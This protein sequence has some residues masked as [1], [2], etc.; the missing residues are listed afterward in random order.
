MFESIQ[1][2][3]SIA[4]LFFIIGSSSII[5]DEEPIEKFSKILYSLL[6]IAISV[7]VLESST[8]L[9][10]LIADFAKYK[11]ISTP[12]NLPIVTV[13]KLVLAV[14][15]L[16]IASNTLSSIST[17]AL[18]SGKLKWIK[19]ILIIIFLVGIA[20]FDLRGLRIL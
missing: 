6:M 4:L 13:G 10:H 7:L 5:S 11:N 3:V 1:T 14:I 15:P 9:Q 2:A 8:S 17:K 12:H 18:E 16:G 19:L 20:I